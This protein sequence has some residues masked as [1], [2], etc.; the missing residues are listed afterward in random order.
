[1]EGSQR[2]CI[3]MLVVLLLV[4]CSV[5]WGEDQK[6]TAEGF[7]GYIQCLSDSSQ[8]GACA[9]YSVPFLT[10]AALGTEGATSGTGVRVGKT[11]S[12]LA[13]LQLNADVL[14]AYGNTASHSI[15][16]GIGVSGT[17]IGKQSK[18]H[19]QLGIAYLTNNKAGWSWWM[20]TNLV[21]F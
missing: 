3:A 15:T 8:G 20:G 1:M 4:C 16:P 7:A 2:Y 13:D 11:F 21:K 18:H 10:T 6:P 12:W 19:I 5:S 9:A 17:I 14:L